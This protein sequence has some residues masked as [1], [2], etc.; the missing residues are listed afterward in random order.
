[1]AG[2]A[3]LTRPALGGVIPRPR[4]FALLD[5][6]RRRPV[7]WITGPAGAGK[8]TLVA[9]YVEARRLPALW[10]EVDAGDGDIASFFYHLGRA[11]AAPGG[12]RSPLPVLRAEDWLRLPAFTRLFFQDVFGRLRPPFALVLDN[13]HEAPDQCL[14]HDVARDAAAAL[15]PGGRLIVAS[16][17]GPPPALART[18]AGEALALVGWEALRLTPQELAAAARRR[19][20]GMSREAVRRL[21]A[22][23]DGWAAGMTLLLGQDEAAEPI[24]EERAG[25]EPAAVFDYFAAEIFQR[26][27]PEAQAVLLGTAFL[28]SFTAAMAVA[29]TGRES[30]EPVLG[31]LVRGHYFTERRP[32]PEPLFSYHPL[33]R[34]FL[35]AHVRDRWPA[36]QVAA[37][38]RR[39][40]RL[41]AGAGRPED[42]VGL[43]RA[44]GDWP[45]LA[46]LVV[47]EAPA[48]LA[49]GRRQTFE[50]WVAALPAPVVEGDAWLQYWLGVSRTPFE[51]RRSRLHL[52]RALDLFEARGDPTG[53]YSAWAVGVGSILYEWDDFTRLD[54][55]LDRLERLRARYPE[56]PSAAVETRVTA[57]LFYALVFRRPQDPALPAVADR[58]LALS[59][60]H[61]D[62][63]RRMLTAAMLANYRVWLGDLA[64]GQAALAELH[65]L[66]RS[67]DA[68]PLAR[69]TA[70]A[71]EAFGL[72]HAGDVAGCRRAVGEGLA[73]SQETGVRL[74][75]AQ[76][77]AQGTQAALLAGDLAGAETLLARTGEALDRS[78]SIHASQY[79]FLA[80]RLAHLRGEPALAL[81]H[82]RRARDLVSG[83]VFPEA[84][85]HVALAHIHHDLGDAVA[86]DAALAAAR[87]M[88]GLLGSAMLDFMCGLAEAAIALDRG[89]REAGLRA[90]GAALAT[91][92]SRGYVATP[93]WL[94]AVMA[95]LAAAALEAGLEPAYVQALV[96]RHRL[97]PDPPPVDIAAWPWA[98]AITTLGPFRLERDGAPVPFGRKVQQRPLDLLK[99]LIALGGREVPE[100]ALADAL[101]P[102]AQGDTALQAL[103]TTLHRLRARWTTRMRS[104]CGRGGSPSTPGTCGWT[105][106]PSSASGSAPRPPTAAGGVTSRS[107]CW[108]GRW[109]S[110]AGPSWGRGRR[111]G[112]C[113]CA[114]ASAASSSGS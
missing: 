25:A 51:P 31:R 13:Y 92:R 54:A 88:A 15:P 47:A 69:L 43:L 80:A 79:H 103:A 112:P 39:A 12:R 82:A 68:T 50:E 64:A 105:S 107:R 9:G 22:R 70:R 38:Q 2:V 5:R 16:R 59:R 52:E 29:L 109:P 33:F 1:V 111:P 87:R 76:L 48:L 78:Q 53:A 91:G 104:T 23:T 100:A 67:P 49:Q 85:H 93:C 98:V 26:A 24:P 77:L 74:F 6:A 114:S 41:L 66:A 30:A 95:R 89:H 45:E 83:A 11:A 99:A 10:Y 32:G 75:D 8:T 14:L 94:P 35:L 86:A 36:E 81:E 44:A 19:R 56:F 42:A 63:A 113:P 101:W 7:V 108:S 21:H 55:W 102:D 61:G 17:D 28:P 110:T 97:L 40:A 62:A 27:D 57:N 46:A 4:L 3:K 84:W 72:W 18:R 90:L 20:P 96:R 106:G 71:Q 73:V 65:A 37:T 34:D 58:A 60:A